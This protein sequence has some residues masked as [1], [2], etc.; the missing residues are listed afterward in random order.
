[1]T[2]ETDEGLKKLLGGLAYLVTGLAKLGRIDPLAAR[3]RGPGFEWAGEFIAL[4]VGNGRQAGGGQALCPDALLDDGL[5]DLTIVPT[6]EGE[7][8]ATLGA[9]MADGKR[10]A[11]DRVATR[12]RLPWLEIEADQPLA[13]NLDGEPVESP[14]FRIEA[15]A[16]RLRMHLPSDCPLLD[17]R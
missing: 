10:A 1:V 6:L 13:L 9:V 8:G 16:G 12:A 3:V 15:V 4:G 2:L 5:L 17:T 11:L 14:R 7:V